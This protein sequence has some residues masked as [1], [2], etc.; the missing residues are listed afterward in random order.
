VIQLIVVQLQLIAWEQL[1]VNAIGV[2]EIHISYITI[3]VTRFLPI[4]ER[5]MVIC[6]LIIPNLVAL[7]INGQSMVPL[8]AMFGQWNLQQD[9]MGI[10]QFV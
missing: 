4:K 8:L 6:I 1:R 2:Q 7:N 3:V 5:F 9:T 10:M